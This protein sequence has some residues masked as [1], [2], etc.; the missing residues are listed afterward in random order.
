MTTAKA[1]NDGTTEDVIRR[2]CTSKYSHTHTRAT[3]SDEG[4]A[5]PKSTETTTTVT[6]RTATDSTP[7]K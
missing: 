5:M 7:P 1:K 4:S 3:T 2:T 6:E